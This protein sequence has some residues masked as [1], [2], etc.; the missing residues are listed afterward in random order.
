M[1]IAPQGMEIERI[2][3]RILAGSTRSLAI[4]SANPGDG[5]TSIALALAQRSLLAGQSTLLVDLN[6]YRPSLDGLLRLDTSM[7][8]SGLLSKP[9]LVCTEKRTIALTGVTAPSKRDIVM[10]LRKPGILE[11]CISEWQQEFDRVIFD[12]APLNHAN[13][14]SI[15]AERVAAACE[16]SLLV[17]LAGRTTEAMAS[18]AV[19]RLK[20]NGAQLLGCV[21]NDRDNPPLKSELLREVRRLE[22]RFGTLAHRFERWIGKSSLLSLEV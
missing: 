13:E 5:V 19:D 22:S 16:G 12:T 6:L 1:Q 20:S 4:T 17:V 18:T 8:P 2:Y 9:Q 11:E 7:S 10:K 3:S 14:S 15:P 21:F